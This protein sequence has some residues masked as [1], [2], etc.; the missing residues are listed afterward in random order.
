[1]RV[2]QAGRR[3]GASMK[4]AYTS[5]YVAAHNKQPTL[6]FVSGLGQECCV[7]TADAL[8]RRREKTSLTATVRREPTYLG[9]LRSTPYYLQ[10]LVAR[11][12]MANKYEYFAG[13]SMNTETL[14]FGIRRSPVSYEKS[15]TLRAVDYSCALL[16]TD[17]YNISTTTNCAVVIVLAV[18]SSVLPVNSPQSQSSK[19]QD[20]RGGRPVMPQ[21]R[22]WGGRLAHPCRFEAFLS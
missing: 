1:M 22:C 13:C 7:G 17:Y 10:A 8:K 3:A 6:F 5:S 16:T 18:T 20:G 19:S 11:E 15:V 2:L 21:E 14:N 12:F 9:I 4:Q